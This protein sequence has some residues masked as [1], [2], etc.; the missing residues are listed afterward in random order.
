[1]PTIYANAEALVRQFGK[2]SYDLVH[3]QNCID[4]T[5]NPFRA[6]EQMVAVSKPQGFVVLYHAENEGKREQYRQLH[7]WDFTCE[8]GDFVIRDR[9]G[10][11]VNLTRKLAAKCE[12]ECLVSAKGSSREFARD[13]PERWS[14]VSL[15]HG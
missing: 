9:Q 6:I 7:Q 1:V 13:E 10:R 3:G 14:N 12:V 5:A 2:N 15:G 11:A 8:K 4:H